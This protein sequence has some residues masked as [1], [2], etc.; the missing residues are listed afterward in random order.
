MLI[1]LKNCRE[2]CRGTAVIPTI[3]SAH[4]R[5]TRLMKDQ[6]SVDTRLESRS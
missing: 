2:L 3:V 5:D 6:K 4:T 1:L